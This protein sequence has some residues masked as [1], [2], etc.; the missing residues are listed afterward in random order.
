MVAVAVFL[1]FIVLLYPA[2]SLLQSRIVSLNDTEAL[3]ERGNRLL[4]YLSEKIGSS[5]LIIGS[6][7]Y[8]S[9]CGTPA[10]NTIAH[11]EGNPYDM[12]TILTSV[13]IETNEVDM[14][15]LRV[16]APARKNDT[17]V[18]V[19]TTDVSTSFL[20]PNGANNAKALVTFDVLKPTYPYGINQWNGTVYTVAA[21]GG[22]ALTLADDPATTDVSEDR[23]TQE[24]NARSYVFAVRMSRFDVNG[25]RELREVGW[26]RSC[27]N[28][29]ETLVLDETSGPANSRGGIDS[30]QFQYILSSDPANLH[31]SLTADDLPLLRGVR[32]SLLIRAGFPARDYV[33][34]ETYTVG[35]LPPRVFNDAYKRMLLTRT[36]ELKNM[37]LWKP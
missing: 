34:D 6:S 26:N 18:A 30:L 32:I 14:P 22:G 15:Y 24:I 23:L 21:A 17:M 25:Q 27:T 1:I 20:D 37:G 36:V 11:E 2:F 4:D 5:G 29:G 31:S 8:I 3:S 9:F 33:N 16:S 7:P 12:I 13:P 35:N 28:G 19:N 10:V